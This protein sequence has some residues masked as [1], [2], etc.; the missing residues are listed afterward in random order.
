MIS[1][2]APAQLTMDNPSIQTIVSSLTVLQ[3]WVNIHESIL[4]RYESKR[5]YAFHLFT[6][7]QYYANVLT[8]MIGIVISHP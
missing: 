8:Q 6:G 5:Y 7:S 1:A 2:F 3:E 4:E